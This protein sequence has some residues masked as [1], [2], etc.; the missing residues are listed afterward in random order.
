MI[1]QKSSGVY[2]TS[3]QEGAFLFAKANPVVV[4]VVSTQCRSGSRARSALAS[5]SATVTS[6]TLTACSHVDLV[7]VKR[8]RTSA[9]YI[10]TRCPNFSR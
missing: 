10:P 2:I 7:F 9:L 4:V 6:P 1:G 8:V 5:L 3:I